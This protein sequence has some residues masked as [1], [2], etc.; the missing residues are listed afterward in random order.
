LD[1]AIL[2]YAE[3]KGILNSNG[4]YAATLN[5]TGSFQALLRALFRE[6]F[7]KG[8]FPVPVGPGIGVLL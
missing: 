6:R 7:W 2:A 4:E 1:Q 3:T 5:G 8:V